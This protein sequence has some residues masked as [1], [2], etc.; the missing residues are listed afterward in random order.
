MIKAAAVSAIPLK[1]FTLLTQT[2]CPCKF[3]TESGLNLFD[4]SRNFF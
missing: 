1:M 2:V 4:L 3:N